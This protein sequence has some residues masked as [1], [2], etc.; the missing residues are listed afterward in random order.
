VDL[1]F[2]DERGADLSQA[3]QRKLERVFS[4][5][6]FRRA[7]PGE[8]A[9]LHHPARVMENYTQE[10][11]RCVDTSGVADAGLKIV[12]DCAG[13]AASMIMPT[14]LGRLG[15]EVLTVNVRLD[16]RNPA[17]SLAERRRELERLGELV[18]SSRAAFGVRFDRVGERISLVDERGRLVNDQRA[19]LVVADLVC[20]ERHRGSVALP[21]TTTRVVERVTQYHGAG[22]QWTSTSA[23]ELSRAA[24][25]PDT[26]FAADGRGGFIVPEFSAAIDG[27]AAFVRLLGLVARTRLTLS[28]I[29]DRIPQ[30]YVVHRSVPTPWAAKGAVMRSV[31]EAAGDRQT[32]LT[33]GVRIVEGEAGWAL[34]LPDPLEAVTHLWAEGS[35]SA[36][37]TDLL[38]Q[39]AE[40]VE[41]SGR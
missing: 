2:L 32:D 13:G 7:F 30:A 26:M 33:D 39:W 21:V 5:Q 19:L 9:D 3:N 12:L 1:I 15:A 6:E 25:Q 31:L 40:V 17:E 41:K 34:V 37:A 10:L 23:D 16:E 29:D 20:A 22:I 38:E 8:I 14:L 4:R 11:L 24:A 27:I 35:D 36:A 18:A 28:Q